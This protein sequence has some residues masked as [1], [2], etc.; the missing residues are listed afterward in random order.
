MFSCFISA[1]FR[2]HIL[3]LQY[4]IIK[5]RF[6]VVLEI[7]A[8]IIV[9]IFKV[10]LLHR[11]HI[12][13]SASTD[14]MRRLLVLL[15][16]QQRFVGHQKLDLHLFHLCLILGDLLVPCNEIVISCS[17]FHSCL[18][19]DAAQHGILHMTHLNLVRELLDCSPHP[20]R[21]KL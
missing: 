3:F 10:A 18:L 7:N 6:V 14:I 17:S 16:L 5:F 20:Q 8:Q 1:L 2:L 12:C 19:Q 11:R 13:E 15:V 21:C 9:L 4:V